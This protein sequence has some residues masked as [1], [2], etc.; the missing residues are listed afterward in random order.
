MDGKEALKRTIPGTLDVPKSRLRAVYSG[1]RE[2]RAFDFFHQW[3]IYDIP[4][5]SA[6]PVSM[7]E[8]GPRRRLT[9]LASVLALSVLVASSLAAAMGGASAAR[10]FHPALERSSFLGITTLAKLGSHS[11]QASL[12]PQFRDVNRQI[13]NAP[14]AVGGG[15]GGV[16]SQGAV[17]RTTAPNSNVVVG[18]NGLTSVDAVKGSIF[19]AIDPPDQGLCVGHGFV[20]ETINLAMVVFDTHGKP[21]T[22][23]TNLDTFF[24]VFPGDF[25]FDPKCYFDSATGHF[26][27]TAPDIRANGVQ[28]EQLIAVSV[29]S[30]PTG[31]LFLYTFDTSDNARAGCAPCFGDQP[32]IGANAHGFFISTNEFSLSGP[33]FFG[34]QLYAL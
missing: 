10:V 34:A 14:T 17:T 25:V 29:T 1:A 16:L 9:R 13:P 20:V 4:L 3:L 24:Q 33:G 27:S 8:H 6:R 12:Q 30:D 28:S 32:L 31:S 7:A 22:G 5:R 11:H 23:V 2:S 18:F 19:S 15:V 26:F 21:L